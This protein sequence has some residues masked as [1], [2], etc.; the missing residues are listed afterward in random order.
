MEAGA[1]FTSWEAPRLQEL[2]SEIR[3]IVFEHNFGPDKGLS[4]RIGEADLVDD[5]VSRLALVKTRDGKTLPVILPLNHR[6][7]LNIPIDDKG[8]E[9][10]DKSVN[11]AIKETGELIGAHIQIS[12]EAA[13][14]AKV[15]AWEEAGLVDLKPASRRK[16]KTNLRQAGILLPVN[17]AMTELTINTHFVP[18][19]P[20]GSTI[21]EETPIDQ[22]LDWV[23]KKFKWMPTA[24]RMTGLAA[25]KTTDIDG[26]Q[27]TTSVLATQGKKGRKGVGAGGGQRGGIFRPADVKFDQQL[28]TT[29]K[30]LYISLGLAVGGLILA[31]CGPKIVNA[32]DGT[33][34]DPTEIAEIITPDLTTTSLPDNI[35]AGMGTATPEIPGVG[36]PSEF[37]IPSLD[38][39]LVGR[40]G[41]FPEDLIPIVDSLV[42]AIDGNIPGATELI[43]IWNNGPKDNSRIQAYGR[44]NEG[45][46]WRTNPDGTFSEYPLEVVADPETMFKFSP[47]QTFAVMPGSQDA[48]VT[49][50]GDGAGGYGEKTGP[51]RN[52]VQLKSGET[53]YLEF[54]NFQTQAWEQNPA[55]LAEMAPVLP[56]EFL[57]LTSAPMYYDT[58]YL[59]Q[60][61]EIRQADGQMIGVDAAGGETI[62]AREMA[63]L[64]GHM[65]MTRV[66]ESG[67]MTVYIDNGWN[68]D[69]AVEVNGKTAAVLRGWLG[70]ALFE[71]QF[72]GQF[73]SA[74]ALG[75][76]LMTQD[77]VSLQLPRSASTNGNNWNVKWEEK[78][79]NPK[80][81]LEIVLAGSMEEYY[82][83]PSELRTGVMD[84]VI[85]GEN[86]AVDGGFFTTGEDGH[87][88]L[89]IVSSSFRRDFPLDGLDEI[90]QK[91]NLTLEKV[92]FGASERMS[93]QIEC[94]IDT[95]GN[96]DDGIIAFSNATQEGNAPDT[97]LRKMFDALPDELLEQ[98]R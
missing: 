20:V 17:T 9:K 53:A 3:P 75:N 1:E 42:A 36:L 52:P 61:T 12:T 98:Y 39:S 47:G 72:K 5:V 88:I 82:A 89:V 95:I 78:Q 32:I 76:W 67:G 91:Y 59:E 30:I 51:Q 14:A 80:L 2:E 69:G 79:W 6:L 84:G 71:G 4:Q 21:Y 73:G 92:R 15:L 22:G 81:P 60:F 7:R 58:A 55:V 33:E 63:M 23:S 26:H 49:F 24:A 8:I 41:A 37:G 10:R 27:T 50:V 74:E 34:V 25:P 66:S 19:V 62:L 11:K 45:L 64:D 44:S 46:I 86:G 93:V 48:E 18:V 70:Q 57:T 13:I 29:R 56:P 83:L 38:Q 35:V 96:F 87:G 28:R 90:I 40:G 54:F 68:L 77:S 65:E 97:D 85:V 31:G 94:L 16:L 43:P